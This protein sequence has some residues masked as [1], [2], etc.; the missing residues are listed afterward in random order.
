[1]TTWSLCQNILLLQILNV[2]GRKHFIWSIGINVELY[3]KDYLSLETEQKTQMETIRIKKTCG[4]PKEPKGPRQLTKLQPGTC[5][6]VDDIP[7]IIKNNCDVFDSETG[8][9][10]ARF[11]KNILSKTNID[12]FYKNVFPFSKTKTNF[13]WK[14]S[15]KQSVMSNIFG[16]YD[17]FNPHD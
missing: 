14:T 3:R 17:R 10:L 1:M 7:L 16:Y 13:R 2:F 4:E 12:L 9:L 15:Q 5:L 6:S 11:R 8:N